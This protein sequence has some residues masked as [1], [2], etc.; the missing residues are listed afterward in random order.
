MRRFVIYLVALALVVSGGITVASAQSQKNIFPNNP[1][2][3]YG[4]MKSSTQFWPFSGWATDYLYLFGTQRTYKFTITGTPTADRTITLPNVAG[5]VMLNS[6][7]ALSSTRVPFADSSGRLV[8]DASFTYSS[9]TDRL[10]V[11]DASFTNKITSAADASLNTIHTSSVTASGP[12]SGASVTATG[13]VSGNS[14]HGSTITASG[15]VSGNSVHASTGTF[16]NLTANRVAKTTTG[17]QLTPST[18]TDASFEAYLA[19]IIIDASGTGGTALTQTMMQSYRCQFTNIGQGAS[20]A[21]AVLPLA[22]PSLACEGNV[23]QAQTNKYGVQDT[24]CTM[25]VVDASGQTFAT[26]KCYAVFDN[27]VAGQS[28]RVWT[29][30]TGAGTYGWVAKAIAV[31]TGRTFTG[32]P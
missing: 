24:T 25:T 27:A 16:S 7:T 15:D 8:D 4:G 31:G 28:F 11:Y 2:T 22:G 13:D 6:G 12:I 17:G 18:V 14:V 26:N 30:K 19:P 21:S 20:D 5:T 10:T 1:H 9:T 32:S 23:V 3:G 29:V